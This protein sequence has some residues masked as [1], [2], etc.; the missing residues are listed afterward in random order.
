MIN[1]LVTFQRF[2][3]NDPDEIAIKTL[4]NEP[5]IN[6]YTYRKIQSKN[7]TWKTQMNESNNITWY[8]QASA[9]FC[10]LS[11]WFVR[12]FS[13]MLEQILNVKQNKSKH[14]RK[15]ISNNDS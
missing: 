2:N 13:N 15:V 4:R 1:F 14:I 8:T 11:K 10:R 9:D 6:K 3:S 5:Y 12:T 7:D